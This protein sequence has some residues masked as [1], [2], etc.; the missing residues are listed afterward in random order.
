MKSQDQKNIIQDQKSSL[1]LH[2]RIIA[3]AVGG[4]FVVIFTTPF[5]VIKTRLQAHKASKEARLDRIVKGTSSVFSSIL[6]EQGISGFWRGLS[7]SLALIIPTNAL[8]FCQYEKVR[9][10]LEKSQTSWV[11]SSSAAMSGA[12]ARAT[13]SILVA[14]VDFLRTYWQSSASQGNKLLTQTSGL[15]KR[16]GF[17][18]LWTGV[19]P[20]LLRDV[21]F[22]ALYW[23]LYEFLKKEF[24]RK[25]G[26]KPGDHQKLLLSS[27]FSGAIAGVIGTGL[28][29]PLDVI[30]TRRQMHHKDESGKELLIRDRHTS[31]EIFRTILREEGVKG[32]FV[33]VGVRAA[34]V[35]P[36]CA[37]MISSYEWM[38]T[39]LN[40]TGL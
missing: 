38:K 30:K 9:E 35:A 6:K 19:V 37:I 7:P 11:R 34:R 3:S 40:N 18:V 17:S 2:Q 10:Q 24:N 12:F 23:F 8:Y 1:L 39:F 25:L 31:R 16:E 32:F 14:P 33:G 15:I 26:H 22:S 5:D 29:M 4:F 13:T 21:P 20:S 27:F 28:T 36:A